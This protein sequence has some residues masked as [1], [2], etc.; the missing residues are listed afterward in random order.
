MGSRADKSSKPNLALGPHLAG[1]VKVTNLD[2]KVF[3]FLSIENGGVFV[4]VNKARLF[5]ILPSNGC[6][7]KL[8]DGAYFILG[9]IECLV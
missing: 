8:T 1:I 5:L 3:F 4:C 2:N 7:E 6:E 9:L